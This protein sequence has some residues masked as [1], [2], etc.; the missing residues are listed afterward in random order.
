MARTYWTTELSHVAPDETGVVR[1]KFQGQ[2]ETRWLSL[3]RAQFE[4]IKKTM[5]RV[6]K[7]GPFGEFDEG[8]SEDFADEPQED[9]LVTSDHSK[10][11]QNGKIVLTVSPDASREEMW[12]EL[13][14]YMKRSNFF[15]NVWFISDHGNTHLMER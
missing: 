7:L 8:E 5:R 4:A 12:R 10:F 14:R 1:V 9:D 11:Y 6:E 15:P 2:G 3:G 13:D